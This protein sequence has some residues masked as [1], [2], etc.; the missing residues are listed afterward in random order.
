MKQR[1]DNKWFRRPIQKFADLAVVIKAD[2]SDDDEFSRSTIHGN[3]ED[4]LHKKERISHE[5]L[6]NCS[7]AGSRFLV[8]GAP[9]IGKSTLALEF[10]KKWGKNSFFLNTNYFLC[11]N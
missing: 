11:Y 2:L 4:I 8:E 9:G 6:Q 5:D 3:L 7:K 10:C 1:P